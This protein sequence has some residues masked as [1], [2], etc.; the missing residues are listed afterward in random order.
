MNLAAA[1]SFF[2]RIPLWRILKIPAE[3]YKDVVHYWSWSGIVTSLFTTIPIIGLA[4]IFNIEIAVIVAII[5]RLLLT[6][7]LH[8]DGLADYADG[9]G[10]GGSAKKILAIMKDSFIGSYGTI[11]LIIYFLIYFHLLTKLY[12]L[13]L[14]LAL[15]FADISSRYICSTITLLL[16]Y[17]RKEGESKNGVIYSRGSIIAYLFSLLPVVAS[18]LI[19]PSYILAAASLVTI[20]IY[21]ILIGYTKLKIG[22]YTGDCCGALYLICEISTLLTIV[23]ISQ[24]WS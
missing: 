5:A 17:A 12:S 1:I 4:P 16:P 3:N 24:I 10:G 13:G 7:A 18:L 23:A 15:P 14:I 2:T 9:M 8:E 6:G 11:T 21:L 19:L 20:I 22:G